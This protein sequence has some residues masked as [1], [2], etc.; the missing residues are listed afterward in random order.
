MKADLHV[1]T[2][3]ST[4]S[5][6]IMKESVEAAIEK[7]LDRIAFTEHWDEDYPDIYRDDIREANGEN[8]KIVHPDFDER[9]LFTF[10]FEAYFRELEKVRELYG[11]KI[12]ILSG[13]ELGLRPGRPDIVKKYREAVEKYKFQVVL[14][15]VHLVNDEDPYYGKMWKNYGVDNLVREYF[16]GMLRSVKEYDFFTSLSHIDYAV[17]YVPEDMIDC[18]AEEYFSKVYFRNS[19]VIDEILKTIIKRGQALEINTKG[20]FMPI[21]HVHPSDAILNRYKELGGTRFT[22]G[23][24]AHRSKYVGSLIHGI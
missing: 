21:K 14:G 16:D 13:I 23:S 6:A 7:G 22:T 4:D 2:R 17:R 3:F 5:S 9:P 18:S 12:E 15:S 8:N 1:H 11:D 24:D 19:E 10:D 20:A